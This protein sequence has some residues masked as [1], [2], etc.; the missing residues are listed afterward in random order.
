MCFP[1]DRKLEPEAVVDK[2]NEITR[3]DERSTHPT[4]GP[5]AVEQI[6]ANFSN[7]S[8]SSGSGEASGSGSGSD[9]Y[10]DSEDTEEVKKAKREPPATDE[11]EYTEKD[12]IL[13][14]LGV[15]AKASELQW[16][17]ENDDDFA[18]S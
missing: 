12:V 11:Y 7:L 15:G 5:E 10:V 8:G 9:T 13:Y 17:Y 18:V 1:N 3:F 4:S 14:N 6:M 16:T 2:W